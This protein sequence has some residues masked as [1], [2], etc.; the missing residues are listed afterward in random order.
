[1]RRLI[2]IVKAAVYEPIIWAIARV[3]GMRHCRDPLEDIRAAIQSGLAVML[4]VRERSEWEQGH[5]RDAIFVPLSRLQSRKS[6]DE[7]KKQIPTDRPVYIHCGAGG[8][9]LIAASILSGHGYD[10][11]A[12]KPGFAALVGAGFPASS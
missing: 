12:L 6:V 1:M 2:R 3:V 11:R 10:A 8:R 7:W 5:L 4:D 9:S